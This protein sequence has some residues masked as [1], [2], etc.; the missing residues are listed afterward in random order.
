VEH[1]AGYYESA[2]VLRDMFQNHMMQLL[3]LVAAEPP[4]LFEA[5]RVRDEKTK[6]FRSLRP[7]SLD[8]MWDFM[9]LGQY[10]AG[11]I[12]GRPVPAYRQEPGVDPASLTPTYATLKVLVDNWRW[13]GVPFY[14]TSGKRLAAK[15]TRIEIQFKEVPYS[16][17]RNVM[18]EHVPTNRLTLDIQPRE[19]ITLTIQA[20]ESGPRLCL[21]SAG[22]NFDFLSDRPNLRY[23][24]YEKVLLDAMIGD[25]TLFWRQDGVELCWAFLDPVLQACE[26]CQD[27]QG[28]LHRY[29][30]GTWGPEAAQKL[31]PE[32]LAG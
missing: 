2:G 5:D 21:R 22:L 31:L 29:P 26:T 25:Q 3:A 17:F 7:F 32:R 16:L 14:I 15:A 12:D 10:E 20:K 27:R 8:R 23:D 30:A 19:E 9:V 24:A 18:G 1:R 4:S 11:Q 6:L 28:R 13:Q